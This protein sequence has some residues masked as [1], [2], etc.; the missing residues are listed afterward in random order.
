MLIWLASFGRGITLV[1]FLIVTSITI[2]AV[3]SLTVTWIMRRVDPTSIISTRRYF[4]LLFISTLIWILPTFL[5]TLSSHFLNKSIASGFIFGAFLAWSFDLVVINGVFLR[6]TIQSLLISAV[7]SI[8]ITLVVLWTTGSGSIIAPITG[9]IVLLMALAFLSR[10]NMIKTKTGISSL[11]LLRAFLKTWVE[12]EPAELEALFSTYAKQDSVPTDIIIGGLN[13]KKVVII[14]PGIHPG[15]FSPVG[16]YNLSE[17][18]YEELKSSEVTPI[19][20]HGTG[21]HERNVPTNKI[22]RDYILT[23]SQFVKA[24]NNLQKPVMRGP[25]RTKIGAVNITTLA[26]GNNILTLVSSSP[27]RSDDLD[28]STIRDAFDVSSA[29]D[30]H[31]VIVDAHNSVDGQNP[32]QENITKETWST[33]FRDTLELDELEFKL[34]V[35]NSNEIGLNQDIDISDG[36]VSVVIFATKLAKYVLVTADSNN[37]KSGLKERVQSE[38]AGLGF[39]LLELCTSDTHKLAATNLTSRGYF[40]LGERTDSQKILECVK[41]LAAIAD[42]RLDTY[43][44]QVVKLQSDIPLI[45]SDSLDDFAELTKITISKAKQYSEIIVP[46]TLLLL[47]ITLFY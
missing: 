28:P 20:L 27:Y 32:L 7:P 24:Q 16:S 8:P 38:L 39:D 6:G 1:T 45:G 10:I 12:H 44:L 29:Q 17:L 13:E 33:I 5:G 2:V 34:G 42:S 31:I 46:I 22:A 21:G 11:E 19:V 9:V 23:V 41:K 30:L 36:G 14:I 3:C 37:A 15:P 47:T 18:L 25:L 40:A 26:I 35:A 4:G 43:Q